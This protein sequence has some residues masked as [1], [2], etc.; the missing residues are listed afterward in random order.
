[1]RRGLRV[2][3][4]ESAEL[5]GGRIALAMLRWAVLGVAA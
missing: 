3:C 2:A 1:M 4:S 5:D